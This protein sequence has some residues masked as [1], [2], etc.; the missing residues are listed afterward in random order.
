M[1]MKDEL[2]EH[3]LRN[4]WNEVIGDGSVI[5]GEVIQQD[6]SSSTSSNDSEASS[7]SKRKLSDTV[8][9][10][11]LDSTSGKKRKLSHS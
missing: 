8:D 7:S 3:K 1:K 6:L 9:S 5:K 10:S 2:P 11:H 4:A